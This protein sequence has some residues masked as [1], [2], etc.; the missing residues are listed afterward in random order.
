MAKERWLM[1]AALRWSDLTTLV[2]PVGTLIFNAATGDTYF[3]DASRS[4]P[5]GAGEAEGAVDP[6]GQIDG[7]IV[8]S[9]YENGASLVPVGVILARTDTTG[10][11][12]ADALMS[13]MMAKCR[14]IL[15]ADGTLNFGSGAAIVG[16]CNM[17]PTF[18]TLDG[19]QKGFIF[20]FVS[21]SLMPA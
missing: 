14:S 3:V 16:R 7:S 10:T 19:I 12:G 1:A 17:L 18:P 11:A 4:S 15:R 5:L 2:T 20:G 6:R 13:S 9:F 8:H 21:A